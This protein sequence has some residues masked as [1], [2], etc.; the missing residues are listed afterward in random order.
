MEP[1]RG[2]LL[3]RKPPPEIKKLWD[4]AE[5]KRT[6]AEWS[7]RWIWNHPEVTVILSGMNDENHIRENILSANSGFSN[8]LSESELNLINR[9]EEK[10]RHL[11]K[12]GCTGCHYC[13][14]CPNGVDIPTCFEAFNYSHMYG[15]EKWAKLFYIARV[16]L[17]EHPG[18]SSQCEKCGEC[19]EACPQK[20][21][22]QKLLEEVTA[23]ME[24]RFFET[25]L[26]VF[27]KF[28]KIQRWQTFRRAQN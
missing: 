20:L 26:W 22:I 2:G 1:L 9:I 21:P 25:K 13:M 8:S 7:L 10:Y 4:E 16:A 12:A 17:G 18:R 15:D 27:D 3:A 24:G 5:E 23:E 11:M 19:E 28:L 14:P 6:P